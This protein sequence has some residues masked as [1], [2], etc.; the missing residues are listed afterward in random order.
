[1][2]ANELR[3]GNLIFN[4][5]GEVEPIYGVD[6]KGILTKVEENGWSMCFKPKPIPLTEEWLLKF[7]FEHIKNNWYNIFA[8]NNTFNVYLFSDNE[9][10]RVEIVSQSITVLKYVHQLQNLYFALTGEE[11]IIKQKP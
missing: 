6:E 2:K 7:G 11:L 1:M 10:F 3:I 5:F 8:V 9:G 4:D